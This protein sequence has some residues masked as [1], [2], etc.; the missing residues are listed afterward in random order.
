MR[1]V[2]KKVATKKEKTPAHVDVNA[3]YCSMMKK[4]KKLHAKAKDVLPGG[5]ESNFR[6]LEPFPFYADYADGSRLFDVDGNEYIDYLLSQGAIMLGHRRKEIMLAVQAQVQKG[7]NFAVPTELCHEV[8]KRITSY[9]PSV[10]RVRFTNSGTEATMHAIRTARGFTGKDKIAKAEGGY[11]GVHDYVLW[12][13]WGPPEEM[14]HERRPRTASFSRGIPKAIADTVC[15]FPFNDI[16]ATYDILHKER[17]N[18]AAVIT[19]PVL[20]NVG[21][22][23]PR[24]HYL[25]ELRKITKEL[26]ILLILDEVITGFRVSRGGA[27]ELFH[28]KPDLTTFGKALGGGFQLAAFGGRKDIMDELVEKRKEWPHVTFHGGTYNAHPVSMAASAAVLKV[29]EDDR[30]YSNLDRLSNN[31]FPALQEQLDDLHITAEVAS[32]GS[33]AHIFFGA[34]DVRT[35]RQACTSTDWDKLSEWCMYC[36]VHGVMFGHPHGEKMFISDAHT[37]EDIEQSLE[38]AEDGFKAVK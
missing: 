26:G 3:K 25:N 17:E 36:L 35:A 24:D 7:A 31:M 19:E 9:V 4:S 28:V 30:V 38:V 6:L 32:C 34:K 2:S 14:G 27:Q 8:A 10:K 15:I 13:L 37:C 16:E 23:L 12:G 18:L 20:A 29:L 5:V 21:V 33:M 22:L 1:G 11:H